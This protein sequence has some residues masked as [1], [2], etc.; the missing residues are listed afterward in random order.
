MAQFFLSQMTSEILKPSKHRQPLQFVDINSASSSSSSSSSS[1]ETT[2]VTAK[3]Q[4]RVS[5]AEKKHV[6]EFCDSLEEGTVWDNTY[7]ENDS[8]HQK[9]AHSGNLDED[10]TTSKNS[11][12]ILNSSINSIDKENYPLDIQIYDDRQQLKTHIEI[13]PVTSFCDDLQANSQSV[14]SGSSA[15]DTDTDLPNVL[16]C[17]NVIQNSNNKKSVEV[18]SR[19]K[20]L[21]H[22][23]SLEEESVSTAFCSKSPFQ[24][25]IYDNE[26]MAFTQILPSVT[27]NG[28][29]NTYDRPHEDG[30]T[31]SGIHNLSMDFTEAVPN[32]IYLKEK[33]SNCAQ[34]CF[35]ETEAQEDKS[36]NRNK[37][38]IK[39][40]DMPM[41]IT[42]AMPSVHLKTSV[43]DGGDDNEV[44]ESETDN[45]VRRNL[46]M[47]MTSVVPSI[48]VLRQDNFSDMV[49]ADTDDERTR[50]FR[51]S[52]ELTIAVPSYFGNPD[53]SHYVQLSTGEVLPRHSSVEFSSN[54]LN[55]LSPNDINQGNSLN[56]TVLSRH[57]SMDFFAIS[58]ISLQKQISES[59]DLM[60]KSTRL[61]RSKSME[62]NT[63]APSSFSKKT[64]ESKV[65]S[66]FSEKNTESRG[67]ERNSAR[68]FPNKLI[69]FT[70]IVPSSLSVE[71]SLNLPNSNEISEKRRR[72]SIP[73]MDLAGTESPTIGYQSNFENCNHIRVDHTRRRSDGISLL[74]MELTEP[75]LHNPSREAHYPSQFETFNRQ[76]SSNVKERIG[77]A[78]FIVK[79]NLS[80]PDFHENSLNDDKS[81]SQIF[82]LSVSRCYSFLDKL[83]TQNEIENIGLGESDAGNIISSFS[84]G[85]ENVVVD[86]EVIKGISGMDVM[87]EVLNVTK[88]IKS[89]TRSEDKVKDVEESNEDVSNKKCISDNDCL[90]DLSKIKN[91]INNFCLEN[92]S[93]II[94]NEEPP[95][96][97]NHSVSD[98]NADKEFKFE[99]EGLTKSQEV[100]N[101]RK[102]NLKEVSIMTRKRSC[103]ASGIRETENQV[104]ENLKS[105]FKK[106]E[107]R[108]NTQELDNLIKIAE[109]ATTAVEGEKI[110][111]RTESE[112]TFLLEKGVVIANSNTSTKI[113]QADVASLEK[114]IKKKANKRKING[115]STNAIEN[116]IISIGNSINVKENSTYETS[117]NF[118][119]RKDEYSK[120]E[121]HDKRYASVMNEDINLN[122]T[123]K[124]RILE[125]SFIL[126]DENSYKKNIFSCKNPGTIR[127]NPSI[128]FCE[129]EIKNDA[130]KNLNGNINK[131]SFLQYKYHDESVTNF[132]VSEAD[133]SGAE[134]QIENLPNEIGKFQKQVLNCEAINQYE[135]PKHDFKT[136]TEEDPFC[137]LVDNIRSNAQRNDCIWDVR[138]L[139]EKMLAFN[140]ISKSLVV[141]IELRS[142][143]EASLKEIKDI[144]VKSLLPD[145][146]KD[147]IRIVHDLILNKLHPEVL[148]KSYELYEDVLPLLGCFSKEVKLALNFMFELEQLKDLNMIQ[149]DTK[150]MFFVTRTKR[151]D[152]IL[153]ITLKIKPFDEINIDDIKVKCLLGSIS[154]NEVKQ[155]I[156]NVRRDYKFLRRIMNDVRDYVELMEESAAVGK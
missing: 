138:F 62:C 76:D 106:I 78:S 93:R 135:L 2:P 42:T 147:R 115:V 1:S 7:E 102:S 131:I 37:N 6:K 82:A 21:H 119:N 88:K 127:E 34:I 77:R 107:K 45:F 132:N 109:S 90:V 58:P 43:E 121:G 87:N 96:F 97:L 98:D 103:K 68:L 20:S 108:A 25:T 145:A 146:K 12:I 69:E 111:G 144:Q 5:F 14:V 125:E 137:V 151:M 85:K 44:D 40:N 99:N 141:I 116:S 41:E 70:A 55:F 113:F 23:L 139:N 32:Y 22:N 24:N 18:L 81:V 11:N 66:I 72:L 143:D 79:N 71:S 67:L 92:N 9:A 101:I 13:A 155:L 53:A 133:I 3:I 140:F 61:F 28:I 27:Q 64:A 19:E 154:M 52:M 104:E 153:E 148:L 63:E 100:L 57:E 117:V 29:E 4:R 26:T 10:S 49:Q 156:I 65:R 30:R 74:N 91:K 124:N 15:M 73:E 118:D 86:E 150:G 89:V 33:E 126:E 95:S 8:S 51:N 31:E 47:E 130:E 110:K 17:S 149:I 39:L 94:E 142:H 114:V 112:G 134:M 36:Q 105:S 129:T 48:P 136:S 75:V 35:L 123:N 122:F 83:K 56:R 38:K 59:C 50:V 80:V 46:S 120:R 128:T 84:D 54:V 60:D 16:I 152:I